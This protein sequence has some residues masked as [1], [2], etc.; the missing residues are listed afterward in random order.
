MSRTS[1]VVNF[2]MVSF[3]N[4]EIMINMNGKRGNHDVSLW[5]YTDKID[6]MYRL[7]KS[8]QI[9]AATAGTPDGTR[10]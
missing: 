6:D 1:P 10:I 7:L 5:L 8:R 3:G 2:G 4:A 9:E